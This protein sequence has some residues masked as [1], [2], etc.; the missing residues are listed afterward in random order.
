MKL[1]YEL[2][3]LVLTDIDNIWLYTIENWSKTQANKYY[4]DTPSCRILSLDS[5]KKLEVDLPSEQFLRIHKSYIISKAKVSILEGNMVHIGKEKIPITFLVINC[6]YPMARCPVNSIRRIAEENI[7][8]SNHLN[9]CTV[10][11][12]TSSNTDPSS[13]KPCSCKTQA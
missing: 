3:K 8:D 6:D 10:P 4:K 11:F 1:N 2:S 12:L 7:N 13:E 5:L 9:N